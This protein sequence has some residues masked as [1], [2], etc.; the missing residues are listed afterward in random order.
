MS[1]YKYSVKLHKERLTDRMA[2]VSWGRLKE[3]VWV[4]KEQS[5]ERFQAGSDAAAPIGSGFHV[6]LWLLLLS[7]MTLF[8]SHGTYYISSYLEIFLESPFL[9]SEVQFKGKTIFQNFKV[10]SG[11]SYLQLISVEA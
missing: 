5:R 11:V 8:S 1:N 10:F 6:H 7:S 2:G 3:L 4:L 9:W